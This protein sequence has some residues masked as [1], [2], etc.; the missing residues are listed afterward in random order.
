VYINFLAG[1]IGGSENWQVAADRLRS[2][3]ARDSQAARQVEILDEMALT[4]DGYPREMPV[5]RQLSSSPEAIVFEAFMS[6]LECTYLIETAEPLLEQSVV[7]DPASGQLRPHPIRTSEGAAFPWVSEDLVINAL[8]RRI[9]AASG[10]DLKAGEPLQVL[11]YRPGQEYR[12]HLDALP[13]SDN[14]RVFTMLVYLN[15]GYRGGE[16]NFTRAQLKFAGDLGDGLLFR[17]ADNEGLPDPNSEHAGLPV[18]AGEKY[19]AS[20]WIRERRLAL[21]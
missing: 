16:T 14:Q 12:P 5:G 13:K 10:T 18:L 7:V 17:N 2:L 4:L 8:N 15:A 9:A 19:V 20:R 11:R 1:G 21:S 3:G 6:P